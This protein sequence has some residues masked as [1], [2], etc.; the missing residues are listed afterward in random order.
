MLELL[1]LVYPRG[2]VRHSRRHRALEI[3]ELISGLLYLGHLGFTV[4]LNIYSQE[5]NGPKVP[6]VGY[7]L[8]LVASTLLTSFGI[9]LCFAGACMWISEIEWAAMMLGL[10]GSSLAM[11]V[12]QVGI[13][14]A[15]VYN[16]LES[17]FLL[18]KLYCQVNQ[19]DT[20]GHPQ[21]VEGPLCSAVRIN[22]VL[23]LL[24]V[25][26]CVVCWLFS[27][28]RLREI[29]DHQTVAFEKPHT[30]PAITF[31]LFQ[32][33]NFVSLVGLLISTAGNMK[34]VVDQSAASLLAAE[35]LG[36]TYLLALSVGISFC[37]GS[38]RGQFRFCLAAG[39]M[40]CSA[41]IS[42]FVYNLRSL[43]DDS[44]GA[45]CLDQR[46]SCPVLTSTVAAQ[47]LIIVSQFFLGILGFWNYSVKLYPASDHD[48]FLGRGDDSVTRDSLAGGLS[49]LPR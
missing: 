28:L 21:E 45:L 20:S 8:L 9:V 3:A 41:Y 25:T 14:F 12:N 1:P 18:H 6:F 27:W 43:R 2:S 7:P 36:S 4:Y 44:Y 13:T 19:L 15:V 46:T 30:A 5:G 31:R 34:F 40:T 24:L 35:P 39:W 37:V 10:V 22:V 23:S 11:V 38:G 26:M 33:F 16:S 48:A 17:D 29:L 47:A 49:P 42:T 32:F